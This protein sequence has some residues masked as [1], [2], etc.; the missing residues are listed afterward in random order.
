[1][2]YNRRDFV[3]DDSELKEILELSRRTYEEEK[4]KERNPKYS[5]SFGVESKASRNLEI[6]SERRSLTDDDLINLK[7]ADLVTEQKVQ[8][9]KALINNPSY[10]FRNVSQYNQ[11]LHNGGT[12]SVNFPSTPEN[13]YFAAKFRESASF[14]SNLCSKTGSEPNFYNTPSRSFS[15]KEFINANGSLKG[16]KERE[17]VEIDS[18]RQAK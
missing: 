13:N 2:S 15:T 8:S 17:T 6:Q 12:S 3:D 1:M 18:H 7:S 11:H 10:Y 16:N 5:R 9:I 4:W 14:S